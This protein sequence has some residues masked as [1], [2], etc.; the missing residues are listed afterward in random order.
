MGM[1]KRYFIVVICVFRAGGVVRNTVCTFHVRE[2][3]VGDGF[4]GSGKSVVHRLSSPHSTN[5]FARAVFDATTVCTDLHMEFLFTG[6]VRDQ[7]RS[8]LTGRRVAHLCTSARLHD[9]FSSSPQP[10][11]HRSPVSGTSTAS[12]GYWCY[13][14]RSQSF[15]V[16][17]SWYDVYLRNDE[18]FF[19]YTTYS[20]FHP[21]R[22]FFTEKAK[23]V[24]TV[25]KLSYT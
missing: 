20:C 23:C 24:S 16:C 10:M 18:C 11:S 13:S 5:A 21:A 2:L 17:V 9:P 7:W 6:T 14:F 19:N 1:K 15:L 8:M 4:W 22:F 3:C 25:H 12:F